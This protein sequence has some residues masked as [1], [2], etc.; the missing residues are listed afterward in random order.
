[1]RWGD[2]LFL[3]LVIA[4]LLNSMILNAVSHASGADRADCLY[5]LALLDLA[6]NFAVESGPSGEGFLAPLVNISVPGEFKGLHVEAYSAILNY[7][8]LLKETN[9]SL[10]NTISRAYRVLSILSSVRDYTNKLVKCSH[11]L[12]SARTLSALINLKLNSLEEKLY[13]L[14]EASYQ[15]S[16]TGMYYTELREG[17]YDPGELVRVYTRRDSSIVAV[18]IYTLPD[19]VK[20]IEVSSSSC[21]DTYCLFEVATPVASYIEQRDLTKTLNNGVLTMALALRL[22]NGSYVL[23]RS[24]KVRYET[25]TIQ[26]NLP[27]SVKRGEQLKVL[28]LSDGFYY[29]E[30]Y[31]SGAL[32]ERAPLRPGK[33]EITIDPSQYR[34]KPGLNAVKV[35]V[36]ATTKTLSHCASGAFSVEPI[37]PP[38]NTILVSPA[39]AWYGHFT[40]VITNEGHTGVQVVVSSSFTHKELRL[41][42]GQV[43]QFNIFG[44]FLPFQ[45]QNLRVVV[46]DTS[47]EYDTLLL[48]REI[49]VVNVPCILATILIATTLS[50]VA[51]KYERALLLQ[52]AR[53]WERERLRLSGVEIRARYALRSYPR[54]LGSHVA[55]LYYDLLE[56]LK[57]RPPLPHETLREHFKNSFWLL[58]RGQKLKELLWRMLLAAE[59]DMYSSRGA[60]QTEVS[61][62]YRG[63]LEVAGEK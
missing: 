43:A 54:G 15:A 58:V 47:G 33:N 49:F 13:E 17:A 56:R 50:T 2:L 23:A 20:L 3:A 29:S 4:T 52:L 8:A 51:S 36:S 63:V 24:I 1:M 9:L 61:E 7:Y 25:P 5:L 27:S 31:I 35:C 44:G 6:L 41:E 30:L 62:V 40:L 16:A 10:A 34:Y 14:I 39:I 53:V 12:D 48:E 28:I 11:N 46:T 18:E 38:V 45:G 42:G 57:V 21:N 32:I 22:T 55:S 19:F 26:L 59:M 37:L 60:D